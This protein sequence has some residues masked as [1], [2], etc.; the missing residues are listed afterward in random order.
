MINVAQ[1]LIFAAIASVLAAYRPGAA[2]RYRV[3]VS[4]VSG[5]I[6]GSSA[7]LALAL[8][9]GRFESNWLMLILSMG[10]LGRVIYCRGDS[11]RLFKW[12]WWPRQ[13]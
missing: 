12:R 7:A 13:N 5:L 8:C 2:A 1:A 3:G 10:A 9:Y 4:A 11:A 6:M